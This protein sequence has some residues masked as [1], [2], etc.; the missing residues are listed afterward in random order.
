MRA[1]ELAESCRPRAAAAA[2]PQLSGTCPAEQATPPRMRRGRLPGA[3]ARG[4]ERRGGREAG[5][6]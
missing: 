6:A 4:R 3:A 2:A 1:A 5:R